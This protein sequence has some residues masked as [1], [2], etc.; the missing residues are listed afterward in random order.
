V[1]GCLP[2]ASPNTKGL[3][4]TEA[5]LIL[6]NH[7]PT[8]LLTICPACQ[9]MRHMT[10]WNNFLL[11]DANCQRLAVAYRKLAVGARARSRVLR[12]R[13]CTLASNHACLSVSSKAWR[14]LVPIRFCMFW[15]VS[16]LGHDSRILY[17]DGDCAAPTNDNSCWGWA[18][19]SSESSS[20]VWV[21]ASSP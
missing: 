12:L 5:L 13:P 3:S 1:T 16:R 18:L 15:S 8:L 9:L 6:H 7:H 19:S 4:P 2:R 14:I 21:G 20:K 17:P 11:P 10:K